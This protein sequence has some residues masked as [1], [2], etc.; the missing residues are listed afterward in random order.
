MQLKTTATAVVVLMVVLSVGC[1]AQ[2]TYSMVECEEEMVTPC[3]YLATIAENSD[4]GAFQIHPKYSYSGRDKVFKKAEMLHATHVV[5][6]AE[7][8][9]GSAA[10]AYRCTD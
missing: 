5:W 4:M 9:F 7:Y 8:P 2:S 6:L 1:A 10:T 3:T